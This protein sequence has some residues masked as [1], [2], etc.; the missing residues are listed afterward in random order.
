MFSFAKKLGK[1][2]RYF[3]IVISLMLIAINFIV[4]PTLKTTI[5]ADY[6]ALD[7]FFRKLCDYF[8]LISKLFSEK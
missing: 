5:M 3:Y 2:G 4:I 8:S 6:Q 7:R 1:P